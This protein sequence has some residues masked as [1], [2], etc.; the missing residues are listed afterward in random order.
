MTVRNIYSF[1]IGIHI[2][3]YIGIVVT[4]ATAISL[5]GTSFPIS[6]SISNPDELNELK[7]YGAVEF[8]VIAII[9]VPLLETSI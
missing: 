7:K 2:I 4:I 6:E 9:L 8:F 1:L 5:I 3:L